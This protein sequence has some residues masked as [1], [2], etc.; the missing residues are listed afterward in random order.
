MNSKNEHLISDE[1]IDL[2]DQ[3]LL[4]DHAMRITPKDAMEH[5]YFDILKED[6]GVREDL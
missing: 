2:L 6:Q 5:P 3:M 1:A 4:Y